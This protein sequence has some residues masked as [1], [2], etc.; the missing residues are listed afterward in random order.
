MTHR[1]LLLAAL[2]CAALPAAAQAPQ[3]PSK[4]GFVNT[5]R[6]LRE[7][8]PAQRAQ[9]K[10]EAEFK[11]RD[12]ELAKIAAEPDCAS[13]GLL[14]EIVVD[15]LLACCW[16]ADFIGMHDIADKY[17]A[18]L[19]AAGDSRELSRILA[20][21]GEAYLNAAGKGR[22]SAFSAGS[23]PGGA[24]NPLAIELLQKNRIPTEGLRSK[25]WDEFAAPGVPRMD[26]V[27][28]VC[29]SAAAEVCPVWPGQPITAHWGVP[30]PAA[31]TGSDDDKRRAM[32]SAY[33]LLSTRIN[34]FLN[35][36][37][38]KLDR[39]KLKGE[40]DKIGKTSPDRFRDEPRG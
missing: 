38:D 32:F 27:L 20:W 17:R 35:L 33:S 8:T 3:P 22:F 10:I 36:P 39:L 28:T 26:F 12:E 24:V 1:F 23:H 19:E 37:L 15:R 30:D 18:R 13:D 25:S 16:E 6:I 2:G 29:D 7:A 40:L 9:K 14:A 21:L 31:A 4:F 5:E 11:K 34:F